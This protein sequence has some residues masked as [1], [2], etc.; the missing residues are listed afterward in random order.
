MGTNPANLVI[1][2]VQLVNILPRSSTCT[3]EPLNIWL[4]LKPCH[5]SALGASRS[6]TRRVL[7]RFYTELLACNPS[8]VGLPID[9]GIPD[10][11]KIGGKDTRS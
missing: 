3:L 5:Y 2:R 7:S 1:L 11:S 6:P 8:L 10:S 9:S 4:T